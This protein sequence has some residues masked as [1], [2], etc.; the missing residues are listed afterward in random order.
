MPTAKLLTEEQMWRKIAHTW[1][2]KAGKRKGGGWYPAIHS[3]YLYGLCNVL[4]MLSGQCAPSVYYAINV[5][6]KRAVVKSTGDEWPYAWP[7]NEKGAK[8]RIAFCLKQAKLLKKGRICART[9]K[10]KE[11]RR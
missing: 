10:N 7:T 4:A 6:I 9:K 8:Q 11:R 3:E 2:T 5:K 1:K